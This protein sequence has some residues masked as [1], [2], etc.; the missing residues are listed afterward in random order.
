MGQSCFIKGDRLQMVKKCSLNKLKLLIVI[1]ILIVAL[2]LGEA[3]F[4]PSLNYLFPFVGYGG[5]FRYGQFQVGNISLSLYW[6]SYL[7]GFLC[8]L[9]MCIQRAEKYEFSKIIAIVTAFLLAIFGYIG[10]KI[11]FVIENWDYVIEHGF[12]L[13][14]ISL[15]G[16]I[17]FMPLV[18][19]IFAR[20]I[21]KRPL[22][23]LDYCTP[24]GLIMIICLRTGCFMNSC[25]QGR[26]FYFYDRPVILPVQLFES[27]LDLCLLYLITVLEKNN[28]YK[29][30]LYVIFMLGYGVLRFFLE[31][32][33]NTPKN[34]MHLSN[35]QWFAICSICIGIIMLLV[36]RKKNI[37]I[38]SI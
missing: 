36:K 31:F 3:L 2:F 26:T 34:I 37:K 32:F 21:K 20:V 19:S 8:M 30:M 16:T 38:F 7:I 13:N 27:I 18:I 5:T 14:G 12:S 23:F 1:Y 4:T 29:G 17:F 10:A 9:F 6:I 28:N 15:F 25:C 24:S 35:G 11:L 33:R 22:T